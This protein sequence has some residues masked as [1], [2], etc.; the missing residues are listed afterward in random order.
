MR[1]RTGAVPIFHHMQRQ[2]CAEGPRGGA[3]RSGAELCA[4]SAYVLEH[5][6]EAGGAHEPNEPKK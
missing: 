6:R 3:A 5:G 4:W 1:G 2:S